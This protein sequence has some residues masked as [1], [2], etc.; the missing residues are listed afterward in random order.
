MPTPDYLLG[1]MQDM[2]SSKGLKVTTTVEEN[3]Q[4][5][6]VEQFFSNLTS[7]E[8]LKKLDI[9]VEQQWPD[10]NALPSV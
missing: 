7:E 10:E 9:I 3:G 1:L 2:M 4:T 5:R 6:Q 8:A